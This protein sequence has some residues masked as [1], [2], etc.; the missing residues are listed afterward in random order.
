MVPCRSYGRWRR[1]RDL[2][3]GD[4][5]CSSEM[6]AQFLVVGNAENEPS[7]S[8]PLPNKDGHC[9]V[10]KIHSSGCRLAWL[11]AFDSNSVSALGVWMKRGGSPQKKLSV[12]LLSDIL[13]PR[14]CQTFKLFAL[15]D[16]Q[17]QWILPCL[18]LRAP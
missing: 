9:L 18:Q 12:I 15:V 6:V 1:I 13:A 7:S 8:L 2:R 16:R 3:R 11:L 14:R 5:G 10:R 4:T 17:E